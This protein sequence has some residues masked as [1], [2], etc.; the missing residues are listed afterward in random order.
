[1]PG[2]DDGH[3]PAGGTAT[4]RAPP[5]A[6]RQFVLKLHSR[7]DLACD[8][9]YVYTMADQRWRGLPRIMPQ[10]VLDATAD[11]IGE[12]VRAHRL[13]RVSVILHGG[14][15]L[16][17]GPARIEAAVSAIRHGVAPVPVRLTVQTNATRLDETYLSLF[18]RLD[19]RLSISLDGDRAAHDRHRRGPDGQGSHARVE[20]AL[21]RLTTGYPHLFNGLLCTVDLRNDPVATYLSLLAHQPPTI[22]F[23]LPHGTWSTP[24]PERPADPRQT[25]YA[26]WLISVFDRWYHAPGRPVRIRLFDEIIQLLLGGASRLAGVGLSPVVVAVVQTDGEIEMDDTLAAAYTGA[27]RTGLHVQR[28]PFDAALD[29]PT[30]RSQQDGAAALCA[31]C[32]ACDLRRVCGGGLRTHRYRAGNGFDNPSVYCPDLYALIG[33]IRQTV[34]RDLATMPGASR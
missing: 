14:E 34:R 19:V 15:P 8:H 13:D 11:R 18:D 7:C 3:R 2:S 32:G 6:F 28:D 1:M 29:L 5:V 22:D 17:A 16:L 25:P 20:T 30:V 9:C 33:H 23:L 27:A 4:R 12:H 10:R 31:T 26:R 24:P 21:R